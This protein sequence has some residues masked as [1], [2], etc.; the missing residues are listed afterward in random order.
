MIDESTISWWEWLKKGSSEK[1]QAKEKKE[2]DFFDWQVPLIQDADV[3]EYFLSSLKLK[4]RVIK[5]IRAIGRCYNFGYW[6]IEEQVE[7]ISK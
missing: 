6:E 2:F 1:E 7:D 4:G 5:S 3:L